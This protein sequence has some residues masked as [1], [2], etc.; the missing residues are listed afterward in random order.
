MRQP[1][2]PFVVEVARIS[3]CWVLSVPRLPDLVEY[4][5]RLDGAD[6]RAR[7]VIAA[8]LGVDSDRVQVDLR[9]SA[10]PPA[11]LTGRPAPLLSQEALDPSPY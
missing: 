4:V 5:E 6:T 9:L 7:K 3:G 11:V 8:A 10:N 2:E 1:D